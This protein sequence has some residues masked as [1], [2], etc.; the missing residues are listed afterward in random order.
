[1]HSRIVAM[2]TM[3]LVV[4]FFC[5]GVLTFSENVRGPAY[6]STLLGLF[7]YKARH[8]ASG[9]LELDVIRLHPE[10]E[11]IV[12]ADRY[13]RPDDAARG[14]YDIA[15]LKLAQHL[16]GLLLLTLHGEEQEEV[17]DREYQNDR[18]KT[19]R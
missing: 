5:I 4:R 10:H 8:G 2:M 16:L 3:V 13:D 11:R 7:R 15:V 18:Q 17:E 1:M 6:D 12:L 9:D 14:D 19:Q